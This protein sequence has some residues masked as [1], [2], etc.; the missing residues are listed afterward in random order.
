MNSITEMYIKGQEKLEG[1]IISLSYQ[2]E[3]IQTHL[4]EINKY[5]WV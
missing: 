5:G 1:V 2:D 4:L 3:G